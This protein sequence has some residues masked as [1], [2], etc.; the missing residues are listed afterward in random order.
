MEKKMKQKD[1][2]MDIFID[3]IHVFEEM[4]R[5]KE[6]VISHYQ[7]RFALIQQELSGKES[8]EF[9]LNERLSM[10]E[11]LLKSK[12]LERKEKKQHTESEKLQKEIQV[13]KMCIFGEY[14][15]ISF[16]C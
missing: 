9:T 1:Q 4:L 5:A 14:Q 2:Q 12:V 16:Y 13:G 15:R 10:A 6:K 7:E 11:D 8:E 3:K